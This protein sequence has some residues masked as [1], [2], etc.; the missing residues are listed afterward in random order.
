MHQGNQKR[1]HIYF[2]NSKA[3]T[4]AFVNFQPLILSTG[5]TKNHQFESL[6]TLIGD[7]YGFYEL[8]FPPTQ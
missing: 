8:P 5:I 3:E 6:S 4:I 1:P 7:N 2:L